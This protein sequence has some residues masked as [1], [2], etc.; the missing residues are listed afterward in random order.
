MIAI[1][2]TTIFISLIFFALKGNLPAFAK[3]KHF[4]RLVFIIGAIAIFFKFYVPIMSILYKT[5]KLMLFA[6]SKIF[7]AISLLF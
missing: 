5:Y 1:L 7:T 4:L 2:L 6:L 3:N